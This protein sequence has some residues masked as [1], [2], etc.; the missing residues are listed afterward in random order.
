MLNI[1]HGQLI[2]TIN[3]LGAELSSLQLNTQEYL[4]RGNRDIWSGRAPIFFP[5]VDTLAND[6]MKY[7]TLSITYEVKTD[8]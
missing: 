1:R 7:P 2:A 8:T 6:E 5:I 4:W 3:A